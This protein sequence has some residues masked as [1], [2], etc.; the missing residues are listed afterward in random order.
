M[1]LPPKSVRFVD[2]SSSEKHSLNRS[3]STGRGSGRFHLPWKKKLAKE[4]ERSPSPD[5]PGTVY[6]PPVVDSPASVRSAPSTVGADRLASPS[7]RSHS[8]RPEFQRANSLEGSRL[9]NIYD[10]YAVCNHLGSMSRG[11]Y[12]S[13]CK[14]PADGNWYMFDDSHVQPITEEQLITQGA[15][16]LFYVRQSLL[17]QSP[18]SCSD[19]SA[20]SSGSSTDHWVFHIPQFTLDLS[21]YEEEDVKSDLKPQPRSRLGS[22][23]SAMSA[24]P[25]T[26][27]RVSPPTSSHDND[28]DVFAPSSYGSHGGRH[29][30]SDARSAISLPPYNP[31]NASAYLG[32]L[33]GVPRAYH[34]PP[35]YEQ[36]VTR[37]ISSPTHSSRRVLTSGR[38]P[39]LRLG[40]VRHASPETSSLQGTLP[41]GGS[42]HSPRH[43][44]VHRSETLPVWNIDSPLQQPPVMPSRSIPNMP[45]EISPQHAPVRSYSQDPD[46]N[47]LTPQPVR[48]TR[49]SSFSNS[50][51][52]SIQTGHSLPGPH[53][54]ESC[55]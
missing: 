12:T 51:V 22:A 54:T 27:H 26:G 41:R 21:G 30:S 23:N 49:S 46:L 6:S 43:T 3:A 7:R 9:D 32:S 52:H 17:V 42:F 36:A 19:S 24:P 33:S 38:H 13:Y 31:N 16:M 5:P 44:S 4:R 34:Q 18:L 25:T 55:V 8:P 35:N 20:S 15:Y 47:F 48:Q 29:H 1:T 14:N 2:Q 39:S 10:L 45:S 53:Q 28:S 11:H 37:A 40:K 50:S